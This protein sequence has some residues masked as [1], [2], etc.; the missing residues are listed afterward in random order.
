M[1]QLRTSLVVAVPFIT[2]HGFMAWSRRHGAKTHP[3]SSVDTSGGY[4]D[5]LPQPGTTCIYSR[6]LLPLVW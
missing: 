5:M 2:P 6:A 1:L 3:M 4:R